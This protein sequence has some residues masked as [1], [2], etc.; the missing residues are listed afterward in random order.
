MEF[1]GWLLVFALSVL[2]TITLAVVNYAL[3]GL[4][5]KSIGVSA[6]VFWLL[7]VSLLWYYVFL[8]APFTITAN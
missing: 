7:V 3:I 4:T 1:I 5:G 6:N 2:A 8:F